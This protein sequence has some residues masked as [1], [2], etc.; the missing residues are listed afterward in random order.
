MCMCV[1]LNGPAFI[2]F[3]PES[4]LEKFVFLRNDFVPSQAPEGNFQGHICYEGY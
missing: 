4:A 3:V 1:F 2:S